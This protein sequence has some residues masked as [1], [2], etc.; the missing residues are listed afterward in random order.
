MEK[1]K[2]I[3]FEIGKILAV[4]IAVVMVALLAGTFLQS[5][6]F[7]GSLTDQ[8]LFNLETCN[9]TDEQLTLLAADQ[10]LTEKERAAVEACISA[11][12]PVQP[13]SAL[14]DKEVYALQ[15]CLLT[16]QELT[17]M[18]ARTD[19]TEKEMSAVLACIAASTPAQPSSVLTDEQITKLSNC[20]YT[21]AELNALLGLAGLTE[22]EESKIKSCFTTILITPISPQP[23]TIQQPI[24]QQPV[25]TQMFI[26]SALTQAELDKLKKCDFTS[27]SEL[28]S[29]LYRTDLLEKERDVLET[30]AA[31]M[32]INVT[33]VLTE[34][35]VYQLENCSFTQAA[36]FAFKTLPLAYWEEAEFALCPAP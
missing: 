32:G 10:S 8:E 23:I 21:E 2:L 16:D 26:L 5:S 12:T 6:Y 19:L 35:E 22:K 29:W 20:D 30:C 27:Q 34:K 9:F 33:S 31:P 17:V 11:S 15:N 7:K 18:A 36:Y 25:N 13:S 24:I 3:K 4:V 14:T 28:Y 1:Q